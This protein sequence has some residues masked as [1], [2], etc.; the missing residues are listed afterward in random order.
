MP[1]RMPSLQTVMCNRMKYNV[2]TAL[3]V[4]ACLPWMNGCA[5][6]SFR[7]LRA[8]TMTT[9]IEP[10]STAVGTRFCF[11]RAQDYSRRESSHEAESGVALVVASLSSA[12]AI[13]TALAA[14]PTT[15]TGT[16]KVLGT[17]SLSA[18]A[19]AAA[20]WFAFGYQRALSHTSGERANAAA[21]AGVEALAAAEML[22]LGEEELRR[23]RKQLQAAHD[24]T[25][26]QRAEARVDI[27][28]LQNSVDHQVTAVAALREA[29][30]DAAIKC[31]PKP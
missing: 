22:R 27:F 29:A 4:C 6:G 19:V 17:I 21:S 24:M 9:P 18:V 7:N 23:L 26:D 30:K 5:S 8:R 13:G 31:F 16:E 3:A 15:D 11:E 28:N 1:W 25:I 12:A 2:A 14:A 20:S 10:P